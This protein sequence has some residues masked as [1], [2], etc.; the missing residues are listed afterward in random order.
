MFLS[1]IDRF[2]NASRYA[3]AVAA[4][5][6]GTAAAAQTSA[7]P[8]D[9]ATTAATTTA[10]PAPPAVDVSTEAEAADIVVTAQRRVQ[11]LQDVPVAVSVVS[12]AQLDRT[13]I[14]TLTDLAVR[15]PNVRIAPGALV[16][17][18]NVRGVG[19][20]N[21]AGFEQSVATF[22][23]G[24]YRSRSRATRAALFDIDQVEILK[25]PQTTFFGA[26]AIAGALN[27][28]TRKP[29]QEFSYNA[30]ALYGT[31]GEYN[32]E[33]GVTLPVTDTLSAR[34]AARFFGMEGFVKVG[35]DQRGPAQDG[36]QGRLSLRWEPD[37]GATSDLRVDIG[38]TRTQNSFPFELIGCPPPAPF[39]LVATSTCARFIAYNGGR[40]VDDKLDGHSDQ[41]PT[42]SDYD[43]VETAW[44]NSADV[45]GGTL[46]GITAY[47]HHLAK[48]RVNQVPFPFRSPVVDGYD[49]QTLESFEYYDQLS[50]EVRFQSESGGAFEY[51]V[52]GYA[53]LGKLK[54]L[55]TAAFGFNTFG[56]VPAV[57]ATGTTAATPVAAQNDLRE[58]SQTLSAF[59]SATIRP[60]DGVRIN[61]GGRY[62][63]IH[64]STDRLSTFGTAINGRRETYAV[65][66]L[67]TQV[68][69]SRVIGADLGQFP[70]PTRT[71]D[72]FMPSAGVQVDLAR[73]VMA[74][75]TYSKGFKAGGYNS[76]SLALDYGPESVNAYEL[77]L[78]G[79]FLDRA[80]TL[81]ADIF[82][83][84]YRDLQ[85]TTLIFTT[86]V[87]TS[88]VANAAGTRSQ[89]VEAS[90]TYRVSPILTLSTDI[91]YLDAKYTDYTN[92]PC[93]IAAGI[94]GC[95][96]QDMSGKR[97][98][99]APEWSGN[100]GATLTLPVA[101][102]SLR[103]SPLVYW[104][105]RYFQSAT[106]DPLLSQSGYAK[107]DLTV[108]YGPADG[109]W[110]L[111]LIGKN[112]TDR[113]TAS[114]R[115]P[116]TG[117]TGSI[118]AVTERGRAV[119]IQFSVRP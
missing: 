40:P 95:R 65:L 70:R 11:R 36:A 82:R 85:E 19:S 94:A 76:N 1:S 97:R 14:K 114:F 47:F 61:L 58:T 118:A 91:A 66:P 101:G 54:Y 31:D 116:V 74:Y 29:R 33:G 67:A 78:K 21:N 63:R 7:P 45:G 59:A 16:D 10:D 88:V 81:N 50:Q 41:T 87:P 32:A 105:S 4:L 71:D 111:A 79:V 30:Q 57:A 15:L 86:A 56:A 37:S 73:D 42:F 9:A 69:L 53:A 55:R 46:T 6:G 24:V 72:K 119:A 34:V 3:L 35:R 100:V 17:F 75:A 90:V 89:G 93:T 84:D 68:A 22:V 13:N 12:G 51:M 62:S 28:T 38:R 117:S 99:F 5:I 77:G 2:G 104:S 25:G 108:G 48:D 44:T 8:A 26:N 106:A 96:S 110:E 107:V 27:I 115:Q 80:L 102:Q 109:R 113:L 52:G 112:L 92:A 83:S 39:T 20:G 98:P 18:L 60:I 49:G 64:K 43:F 23:D 103:V